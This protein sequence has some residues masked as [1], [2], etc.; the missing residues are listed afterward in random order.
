MSKSV[1][2]WT[3]SHSPFIELL[4]GDQEGNRIADKIQNAGPV[5]ADAEEGI[6]RRE[7]QRD[8]NSGLCQRQDRDQKPTPMT[9]T[10]LSS[11]S[12]SMAL[13]VRLSG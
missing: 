7:H 8:K 5:K 1:S 3:I 12:H 10:S 13:A 6:D 9:P 4:F 11:Q 2:A